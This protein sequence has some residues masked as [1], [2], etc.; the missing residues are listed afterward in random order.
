[1]VNV[2]YERSNRASSVGVESEKYKQQVNS[3]GRNLP[4]IRVPGNIL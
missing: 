3:R 1:M 4:A 2:K